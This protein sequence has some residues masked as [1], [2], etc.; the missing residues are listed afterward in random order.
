VD[1][2]PEAPCRCRKFFARVFRSGSCSSPPGR[3]PGHSRICAPSGAGPVILSDGDVVFQAAQDRIRAIWGPRCR[4]RVLN[5][6]AQGKGDGSVQKR[7]PA[8]HYVVVD[9]K[10]ELARRDEARHAGKKMT[11][12]FVRAGHYALAAGSNSRVPAARSGDRAHR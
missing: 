2:E 7:Y 5:L 11:T 1:D 8:P 3:L 10:P 12:V 4:A 6:S 9:D